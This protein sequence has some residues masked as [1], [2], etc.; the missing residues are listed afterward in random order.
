MYYP[1]LLERNLWTI[2]ASENGI[3]Q[4]DE[5]TRIDS[6]NNLMQ[7][8][9]LKDK[10]GKEIYEGDIVE[11]S[12]GVGYSSKYYPSFSDGTERKTI[13]E[14]KYE[15]AEFSCLRPPNDDNF[16]KEF[17]V[18]GNIFETPELLPVARHGI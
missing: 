18:I 6:R 4:S 1:D 10:N 12:F 15:N 16:I 9:G 13:K 7:Y 5:I 17:E 2:P 3:I 11:I 14:V 8:T